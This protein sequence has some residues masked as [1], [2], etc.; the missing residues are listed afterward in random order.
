L[1]AVR[2]TFH[3]DCLDP[4]TAASTLASP[5]AVAELGFGG[6]GL[7]VR[8]AHGVL[9]NADGPPAVRNASW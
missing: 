5:G 8:V 1:T 7:C 9:C 6:G 4:S 2:R 3:G